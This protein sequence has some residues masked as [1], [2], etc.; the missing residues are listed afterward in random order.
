[1]ADSP[2][3]IAE[4]ICMYSK[5]PQSLMR[6]TLICLIEEAVEAERGNMENAA[7]TPLPEV[8]GT[9]RAA[10][11]DGQSC[12]HCHCDGTIEGRKGRELQQTIEVLA[13]IGLKILT[14]LDSPVLSV[15]AADADE[16]RAALAAIAHSAPERETETQ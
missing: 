2:K 7:Q 14:K 4:D 10:Q 9:L 1:M 8:D 12:P 3:Q 13:T 5:V 6:D 15:T 11:G 16:L